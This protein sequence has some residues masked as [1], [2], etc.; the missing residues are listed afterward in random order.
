MRSWLR[1]LASELRADILSEKAIPAR[2]N[3][4]GLELAV[5]REL[6][7]DREFKVK[8][9]ASVL[10]G[11]GG[12]TTATIIVPASLHRQTSLSPGIKLDLAVEVEAVG[13]DADRVEDRSIVF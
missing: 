4:T 2:M 5:D 11:L 8:G 6:N 9:V 13:D 10:A 1:N 7:W 3:L 12:G